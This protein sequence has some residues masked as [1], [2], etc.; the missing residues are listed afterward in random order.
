MKRLTI[1]LIALLGMLIAGNALADVKQKTVPVKLVVLQ[2]IELNVTEP[3]TVIPEPEDYAIKFSYKNSVTPCSTAPSDTHGFADRHDAINVTIFTNARKGATVYFAGK[4]NPN[5]NKN[6]QVKDVY[7]TV[8]REKTYVLNNSSDAKDE[9]S[10]DG[11]IDGAWANA[12]TTIDGTGIAKW[13]QCYTE[14]K[15]FF[16][17]TEKTESTRLWVLKLGIGSLAEYEENLDGYEMDLTFILMP[18]VV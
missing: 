15:E 11:G 12:N 17:V 5:H 10:V 18:K 14:G 4:S 6:L 8:M 13:M 3:A 9:L 2:I 1:G 7:L 16:G